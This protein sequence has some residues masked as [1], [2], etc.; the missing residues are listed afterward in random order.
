MK[1]YAKGEVTNVICSYDG[2]NGGGKAPKR[3]DAMQGVHGVLE[4][5]KR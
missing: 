1:P 5:N 3:G 2:R 4:Q